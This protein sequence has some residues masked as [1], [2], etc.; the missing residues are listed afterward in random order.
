[1]RPI[2]GQRS[3]KILHM[4]PMGGQTSGN[5]LHM[6]PMGGQTSEN[7]LHMGQVANTGV[8]DCSRN[9]IWVELKRTPVGASVP[10]ARST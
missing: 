7:F 2:G 8:G 4:Q 5:I 10:T 1:M 9:R 3:G 6:R